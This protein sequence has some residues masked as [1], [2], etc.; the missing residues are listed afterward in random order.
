[1]NDRC[2]D[3]LKAKDFMMKI[4]VN[5]F[6]IDIALIYN[7]S[8]WEIDKYLQFIPFESPISHVFEVEFIV[9]KYFKK[10]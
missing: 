2:K 7:L 5:G 10:N 3:G 6:S 4:L 8:S 1:M 9:P